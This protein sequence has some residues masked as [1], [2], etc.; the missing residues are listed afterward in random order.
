MTEANASLRRYFFTG[1]GIGQVN[2]FDLQD[3]GTTGGVQLDGTGFHG[4]S[5]WFWLCMLLL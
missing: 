2:G 1:T 5:F 4:F 3:F